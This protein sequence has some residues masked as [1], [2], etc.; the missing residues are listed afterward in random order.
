MKIV[1]ILVVAVIAATLSLPGL[2][3]A[4]EKT[5]KREP[6]KPQSSV[7]AKDKTFATIA[8]ADPA[9]AKATAA[10]DKAAS[11]KLVGKEGALVGTVV[12]VYSPES[13]G[14]VILNFAKNFREAASVILRP[15]NYAKFP[16]LKTLKDKKIVVTGK[17]IDY[18]GQPEI[19]L[20]APTQI[21]IVK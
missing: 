2:V 13:N 20:T 11:A 4:Q 10:S 1:P 21:K 17:V 3:H 8:A 16:D 9:V 12:A 5:E 14:I 19:E 15:K 7:A 18:Q 6:A